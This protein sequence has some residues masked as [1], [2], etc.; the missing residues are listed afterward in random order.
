[1]AVYALKK[2]TMR[3]VMKGKPEYETVKVAVLNDD[4]TPVMDSNNQPVQRDVKVAKAQDVAAIFGRA[5]EH[6][7]GETNFGPFIEYI[8]RFE[9]RSLFGKTK[10]DVFQSTRTIFPPIAAD[11][12]D[13]SYMSA[14]MREPEGDVDFAF[15]I[16]IEPDARGAEG[17]RWTCKPIRTSSSL[18]DPL[19]ELRSSLA[20][21]F[22]EVLGA[23]TM[24]LI[25]LSTETGEQALL[26]GTNK[27][28]T[29][30]KGS[31]E[32]AE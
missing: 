1:M 2:I 11:I 10:G 27:T 22:A 18:S 5:R 21:D 15:V 14:K 29:K 26:I 6:R 17:Y 24:A 31:K 30:G 16:G 23:E 20:L 13:Q 25:G 19:E 4:G 3:D 32:P 8:G 7:T 28:E 9:A 12:A